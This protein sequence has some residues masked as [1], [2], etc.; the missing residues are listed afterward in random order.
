MPHNAL[1]PLNRGQLSHD[2]LL[3]LRAM[4]NGDDDMQAMLG[5]M[6]HEA[7]A[8]EYTEENPWLG[9]PAMLAGVP[10]YT[11]AKALGLHGGRSPASMNEIAQ[12]YRGVGEG[13]GNVIKRWR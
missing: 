13:L 8:R 2:E 7:F 6:E 3:R 10:A 1:A 12:A 5:P 11:A 9:P 4:F